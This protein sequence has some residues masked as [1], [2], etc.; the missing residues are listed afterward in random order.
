MLV[1]ASGFELNSAAGSGGAI[2]ASNLNYSMI[3][4]DSGFDRNKAAGAQCSGS[5]IYHS[6]KYWLVACMLCPS[7]LL[8]MLVMPPTACEQAQ[9]WRIG[10]HDGSYQCT[11]VIQPAGPTCY[12]CSLCAASGGAI[13]LE[14]VLNV[15]INGTV[16]T[17][18]TA[19]ISEQR[20]YM[21]MSQCNML[22]LSP[23]LRQLQLA[24]Y[25]Q[26]LWAQRVAESMHA[27]C[28]LCSCLLAFR[29][30]R[31]CQHQWGRQPAVLR[32]SVRQQQRRSVR[33]RPQ[34]EAPPLNCCPA[35]LQVCCHDNSS[36]WHH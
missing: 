25:L 19:E 15:Q 12:M 29:R 26:L 5:E 9:K 18:N 31:G 6:R 16:F 4:V 17:N 32:Q 14:T 35:L 7:E 1:T 8:Q 33:R 13:D 10:V 28:Q 27:L 2:L 34:R 36:T 30:R 21:P 23:C 24:L 20:P 11:T 22:C 3:V